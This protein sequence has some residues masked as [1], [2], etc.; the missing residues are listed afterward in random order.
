MQVS[1]ALFLTLA[2]GLG[3]MWLETRRW[4]WGAQQIAIFLLA[5]AWLIAYAL[6]RARIRW[7]WAILPPAI[8]VAIGAAQLALHTTTNRWQ[9]GEHLLM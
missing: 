5:A 9:S 1:V 7:H 8:A 3:V 6:G 4:P 2:Y